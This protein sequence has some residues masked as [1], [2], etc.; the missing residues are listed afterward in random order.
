MAA[1]TRDSQRVDGYGPPRDSAWRQVDWRAHLHW[2]E[3]DGRPINYAELGS[4]PPLLLV[5]G[6]AGSWQNW[7][8]TIPYFARTRRVLA[9]DLP[10]F[11]ES[12]MP[13][14]H[15]SIPGYGRLL[16]AF[17]E[18]VGVDRAAVIGNSMG[19]FIAAELAIQFPHRVDRLVLVSAAGITAE[20]QHNERVLALMRRLEF[21][22]VWAVTHPSPEFLLRPR[23]RR[24]ARFVFA[25]PER[26]P[27]ALLAENA[28]GSGKP[29][30]I[31]A[32]DAL[33]SYPI[34]DRL[35]EISAPTLVVWG[36]SDRLVPTRD[37][38]VFEELIPDARK[39]IYE[40]TGHVP[41]L[42]RPERL[43]RDVEA[44]LEGSDPLSA[45]DS[46]V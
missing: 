34:R 11:G 6:L 24:A 17:C 15:I 3:V 41:Q 22:F 4:G 12:P 29:G 20:H 18:A 23:A 2:V 35:K 16:D 46:G 21:V 26:I 39:V 37:A 30:F 40:D 25:H 44:F 1:A 28:R 14:E 43:N 33:T 10:G 13:A 38:D 31:D 32:L 27:G 36:A 9:L 45:T 42:E 19:G 5:H 7:L 8:E